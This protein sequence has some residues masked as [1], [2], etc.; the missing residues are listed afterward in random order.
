MPEDGAMIFGHEQFADRAE[1]GRRLADALKRGVL[2]DHAAADLLVMALPRGGVPVAYEVAIALGAPLDVLLVRKLGAPGQPEYGIGAVVDGDNPQVVLNE[3]ALA[4]VRPS[5]E[6]VDAETRRQLAEI[7]RRRTLYGQG[8]S[9]ASVTGRTAVVVDD[10]IAT[11]GTMRAA[12]QA[13]RKAGARRIVLAVPVAP[14]ESLAE[15]A[16]LADGVVCLAAPKSFHAVGLH[17]SDFDQTSDEEVIRLLGEA[18]R[19]DRGSTA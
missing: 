3:D 13:L 10:G 19:R 17:Y 4:L 18:N 2:R 12:L 6:Y 16:P 11:G 1:A 14:A 15:L 9:P 5:P 7:E 8:R